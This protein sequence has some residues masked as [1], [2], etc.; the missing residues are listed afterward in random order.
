MGRTT[1]YG[2]QRLI[3]GDQKWQVT[4]PD[5]TKVI[6]H[7]FPS[8]FSTQS[9][10]PDGTVQS[11]AEGPD[12][13]FGMLAPITQSYTVK[14]GPLTS[15]LSTRRTVNL[16]DKSNLLSVV[17]LT[18]TVTLNGRTSTQV[19]DAATQTFTTTSPTDRQSTARIDAQGRVLQAQTPGLASVSFHYDSHGRPEQ[20]TQDDGT[21]TRVLRFTYGEDGYLVSVTDPLDRTEGYAYDAA[22]R[23]TIQTLVDGRQIRYT[24]DA[25]GN[26]TSIQPPGGLP[27][28]S[29]IRPWTRWSSTSR[30]TSAPAAT[31]P[32]TPSIRTG[33]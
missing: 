29:V 17:K 26:V 13:R 14:T 11:Q 25:N 7:I 18:D 24:Y 3:E 15:S 28:S 16:A 27:T 33:S 12:P 2:V 8:G 31:R 19:Y 20:V 4:A 30:R 6:S 1:T 32:Y 10:Q 22:G 21:E 9:T 23:L 5:G